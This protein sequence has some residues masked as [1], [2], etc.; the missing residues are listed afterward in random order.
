MLK[1][2]NVMYVKMFVTQSYEVDQPI[3]IIFGTQDYDNNVL[4]QVDFS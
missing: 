2:C 3:W 4:T 1:M